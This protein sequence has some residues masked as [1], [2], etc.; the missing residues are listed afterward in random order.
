MGT[1]GVARVCVCVCVSIQR[2]IYPSLHLDPPRKKRI[3]RQGKSF[4]REVTAEETPGGGWEIDIKYAL[5]SWP[6]LWGDQALN[7]LGKW[8]ARIRH[9]SRVFPPEWWGSWGVYI[10]TPIS[11]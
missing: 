11:P 3:L 4:I 10:P 8:E 5:S 6:P 2:Q 9:M 1:G 7:L